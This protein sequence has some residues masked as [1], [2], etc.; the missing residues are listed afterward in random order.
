MCVC[1]KKGGE[2]RTEL[3]FLVRITGQVMGWKTKK[4]CRDKVD[5][6]MMAND[7]VGLW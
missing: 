1:V 5:I 7:R 2:F 3:K 6:E 4:T